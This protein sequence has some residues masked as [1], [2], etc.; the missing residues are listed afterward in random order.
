MNNVTSLIY[1]TLID[2]SKNAPEQHSEICQNLYN[3]LDLPLDKQLSLYSNALG[4]ASSG[5]LENNADFNNTLNIAI[6]GL[7]LSEK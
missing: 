2:L 6:R 4:P 3:Q 7:G 1:D 5:I